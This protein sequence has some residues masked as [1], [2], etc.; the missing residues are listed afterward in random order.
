MARPILSPP[1]I[2]ASIS[3][4][5][6]V[7]PVSSFRWC[8]RARPLASSGFASDR[9]RSWSIR[10]RRGLRI[11]AYTAE[12]EQGRSEED[13]ADDFYSVLG[14]VSFLEQAFLILHVC[15]CLFTMEHRL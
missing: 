5:R 13:V 12:A 11:C 1:L 2:S 10:G 4:L 14:V 8:R 3:T 7:S 6:T 15:C 9:R